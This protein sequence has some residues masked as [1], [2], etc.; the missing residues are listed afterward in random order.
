LLLSREANVVVVDRV[1]AARLRERVLA[2]MAEGGRPVSPDG[3]ARGSVWVR[4]RGWCAYHLV[5]FGVRVS[6]GAWHW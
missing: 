4:F 3:T 2:S 1:F 5:R 6:G